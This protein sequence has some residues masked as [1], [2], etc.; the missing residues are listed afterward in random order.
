M[1]GISVMKELGS[2]VSSRMKCTVLITQ[3]FKILFSQYIAEY[4]FIVEFELVHL[5]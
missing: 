4:V 5:I 1:I 2:N 3:H